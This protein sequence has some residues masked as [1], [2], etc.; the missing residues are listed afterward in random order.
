MAQDDRVAEVAAVSVPDD[1]LGELVGVAVSLAPGA[2][3]TE[4]SIMAKVNPLIRYP[5]RPVIIVVHPEPL[6]E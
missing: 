5:A 2:S 1:I 6:R 4:A 3:A